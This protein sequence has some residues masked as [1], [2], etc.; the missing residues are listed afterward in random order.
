[1]YVNMNNKENVVRCCR[2]G[3]VLHPKEEE[4]IRCRSVLGVEWSCACCSY[5]NHHHSDHRFRLCYN[6]VCS[7][8]VEEQAE[9]VVLL[10]V[11]EKMMYDEYMS[12]PSPFKGNGT[13][14]TMREMMEESP[15]LKTYKGR[16]GAGL[17]RKHGGAFIWDHYI[18]N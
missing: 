14:M 5:V 3:Y 17:R 4:S 12:Q 8:M 2:C 15:L 18:D 6:R 7:S 13:D 9:M 1:M 10:E 16:C 11:N